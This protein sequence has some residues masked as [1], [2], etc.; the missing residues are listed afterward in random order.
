M[1]D[2]VGYNYRLVNLLGPR[3]VSTLKQTH[4]LKRKDIFTI[5]ATNCQNNIEIFSEPIGLKSNQ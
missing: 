4:F 1:H 3:Q 2:E 5:F